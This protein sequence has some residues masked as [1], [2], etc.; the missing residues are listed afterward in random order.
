MKY[1]EKYP[2]AKDNDEY[3]HC[4]VFFGTEPRPC[5]YCGTVTHFV[6]LNFETHLCSEECNNAKWDEFARAVN[7]KA[8]GEGWDA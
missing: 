3:P 2:N 4:I 5:W 7:K 1:S 8:L 6:E